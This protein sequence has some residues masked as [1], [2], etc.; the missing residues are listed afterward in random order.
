MSVC[1]IQSKG[2]VSTGSDVTPGALNW[3][4]ITD[5]DHDG[6][7]INAALALTA[8]DTPITLRAAWTSSSASPAMGRWVKNG[9]GGAYALTPV[10]V[11]ANL[12]DELAFEM[13][14]SYS[15][16]S[17]NYDTGTV[18]VTNRSDGAATLDTFGFALQYVYFGGGYHGGGG[19][20]F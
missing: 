17:G 12:G 14:A 7:G 11:T 13:D 10:E 6:G 1:I 16:P 20:Y 18:T 15:F 4:D 3:A 2:V 5:A 19:F 8:I 9:A